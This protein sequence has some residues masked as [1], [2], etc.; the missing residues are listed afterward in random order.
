MTMMR[1]WRKKEKITRMRTLYEVAE[2]R[3]ELEGNT[4]AERVNILLY[5][6]QLKVVGI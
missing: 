4:S 6:E 1:T 5:M 2:C 3:S